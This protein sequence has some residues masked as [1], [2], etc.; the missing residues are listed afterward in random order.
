M[1]KKVIIVLLSILAGECYAAT[2]NIPN[3]VN[4]VIKHWPEIAE[5]Y[6]RCYA[7]DAADKE[8]CVEGLNKKYIP[9]KYKS[10][11]EWVREFTYELEKQGFLQFL[12]EHRK[13]C[14]K[15]EE[16]PLFDDKNYAYE[17]KCLNGNTFYMPFDSIAKEWSLVESK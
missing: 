8:K 9:N 13:E 11:K 2:E 6:L 7:L 4:T 14:D 3:E 16:G 5:E 1:R 10:N 15:I 12:K 17:I